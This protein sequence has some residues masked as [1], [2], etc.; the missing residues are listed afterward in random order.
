MGEGVL[1]FELGTDV[2]LEISTTTLQVNK[3]RCKFT[4][5]VYTIYFLKG[6][7]LYKLVLFTM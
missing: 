7:F 5:Y 2:Q 6:P 1:K 3:K 4:T